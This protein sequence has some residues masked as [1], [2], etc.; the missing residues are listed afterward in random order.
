MTA[1]NQPAGIPD[2]LPPDELER[3]SNELVA[4]LTSADIPQ[5]FRAWAHGQADLVDAY[6]AS[7]SE[8]DADDRAEDDVEED[9]TEQDTLVTPAAPTAT[10]AQASPRAV[11][12]P[13]AS[14]RVAAAAPQAAGLQLSGQTGKLALGIVIGALALLAI[15]GVRS[16][17]SDG[18]GAASSTL[19]A[20]SQTPVF[21][22]ARASQLQSILTQDPT[23]KD[24]LFEIGEMSFEAARWEDA[25]SWL[26]K[27]VAVDPTNTNALNDV[28]T[29]NFNLQLPDK[30]K[31]WW[32]K[33][34]TVNANDIQAHYNL[35]FA[36][37]N[38][39]PRDLAAAVTEWEAVLRIDPQSQL[40]QTAKVHIDSMKAQLTATPGAATAVVPASTP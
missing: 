14:R 15:I 35:G 26:T 40:A 22:E 39:E 8:L 34:L 29:A 31:E 23:N 11:K 2:G 19:P 25:I 20:S 4:F 1:R 3:W 17:L 9:H 24:A 6:M 21:D 13:G 30:A 36:Y 33:T 28:G 5:N 7:A 18:N 16:L 32:Q 12:S 37:F 27:L 38:T 10:P